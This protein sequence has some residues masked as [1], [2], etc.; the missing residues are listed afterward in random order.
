[1]SDDSHNVNNNIEKLMKI[2]NSYPDTNNPNFQGIIYKKREFYSSRIPDRDNIKTYQDVQEYRESVCA[3]PF[4][5]HS[6]QNFPA[7]FINPDTPYKGL[8]I[9]YGTGTG[10]C[11]SGDTHINNINMTIENIWDA[12]HSSTIKRDNENGMWSKPT[13][14]LTVDSYDINNNV[15]T[16]Q[17]VNYLYKQKIC[18]VMNIVTLDN[19]M[20]IKV[21]KAHKILG[22]NMIWS[23]KYAI[24]DEVYIYKN[25]K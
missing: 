17:I 18:E 14:E 1:M 3:R 21:T 5:L 4:A 6:Y 20:N 22:K 13:K 15:M 10:K 24:D 12:Y 23:N 2:D 19:G 8:L 16:K 9:F 11:V 7:N 25:D